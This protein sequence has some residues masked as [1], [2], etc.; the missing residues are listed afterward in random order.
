MTDPLLS[1]STSLNIACA[2]TFA[3]FLPQK[4]VASACVMLPSP[5]RSIFSNS[6]FTCRSAQ[7]VHFQQ[8]GE[9]RDGRQCCVRTRSLQRGKSLGRGGMET[10][11]RGQTRTALSMCGERSIFLCISG[12]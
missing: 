10:M 8:V 6:S 2:L 11:G 3:Q 12:L 1:S 9:E 7:S 5:L 4:L